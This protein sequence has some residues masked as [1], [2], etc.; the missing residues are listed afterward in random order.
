[1]QNIIYYYE[2]ETEKK[3]L[4]FLKH[5]KKIRHGKSKK[6]NLWDMKIK[7]IA[8]NFP[9]PKKSALFFVV[10]TDKITEKDI[11]INNITQLRTYNFCLIIQH[12]NFEDELC[13]SC[14]KNNNIQLFKDFYNV[15]SKDKFTSKFNKESSVK[16]KLMDNNFVFEKLWIRD[17][18]FK[19]FLQDN[20]LN[21]NTLCNYR[22]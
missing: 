1:M 20:Y 7:N 19:D 22:L 9:N 2:G 13:Y 6:F 12:K 5:N 16:N 14:E 8:R 15:S 3:L 4:H 18:K 10:D 17:T 21:A 11:F